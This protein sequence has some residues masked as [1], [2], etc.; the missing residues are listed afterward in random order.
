MNRRLSRS[1]AATIAATGL[2]VSALGETDLPPA[3]SLTV[4]AKA[5][6]YWTVELRREELTACAPTIEDS[7]ELES[8]LSLA[9]THCTEKQRAHVARGILHT[10]SDTS[11][12][13]SG[14]LEASYSG[15]PY[16][17]VWTPESGRSFSPRA[18]YIGDSGAFCWSG[19]RSSAIYIGGFPGENRSQVGFETQVDTLRD[20]GRACRG[21]D[22]WLAGLGPNAALDEIHDS[23]IGAVEENPVATISHRRWE[24]SDTG[25]V[26]WVRHA[27]RHADGSAS[28]ILGVARPA[29]F[30]QLPFGPLPDSPSDLPQYLETK[31]GAPPMPYFDRTNSSGWNHPMVAFADS[32]LDGEASILQLKAWPRLLLVAALSGATFFFVL[33]KDKK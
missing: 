26:H 19:T 17:E 13:V 25:T 23:A 12:F 7:Y 21:E 27:S 8:W 10:P 1:A 15:T 4:V 24:D 29:S 22:P 3:R 33:R 20:I 9:E 32:D 2:A 11:D 14:I 30:S 5:G 6:E 28:L 16:D 31:T 18:R